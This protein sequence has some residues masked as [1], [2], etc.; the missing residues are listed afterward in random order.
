[1]NVTY[2]GSL[3]PASRPRALKGR[4]SVRFFLFNENPAQWLAHSSIV[5][6]QLILADGPICKRALGAPLKTRIPK[7]K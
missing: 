3:L 5:D 1:M 7:K 2:A 4:R 6:S